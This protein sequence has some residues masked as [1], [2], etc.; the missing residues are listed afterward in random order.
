MT[1][2]K[3]ISICVPVYNE[4]DNVRPLH[5]R[6]RTVM[7]ELEQRY[8][9]EILFTDN[10]SEDR[11]FERLA[12]LALEDK[13]VRVI[14]FSRN[15]GF[16][17]SILANYVH[18]RGVAAIQLDC[19]LQDPPELITEFLR[20][21][22]EGYSVVYGVRGN[23]PRESRFLYGLR[24]IFYRLID[25]LSEDTLP[26]DAGDFRLIDRRVIEELR[27]VRDQQPYLRGLIAA[28]GFRQIGIPYNRAPR[29]RGRSK[30][31]FLRLLGLALDGILHHST[32]P[33]RLA[34]AVGFVM[35]GIAFFGALY[36][37]VAR[38]FGADWPEGWAS[39][40]VLV[41]F[42]IG[43]NAL[44]LGIIGEYIGRIFKNVKPM[45]LVIIDDVIDHGQDR[46]AMNPDPTSPTAE[47][48][49]KVM[50]LDSQQKASGG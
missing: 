43:L 24:R 30:F 12:A 33:L 50:R 48:D 9:Y 40:S 14:R 29:A 42:S 4:E 26:H 36:F 19:D 2:R 25:A 31:S 7:S 44:L 21:W 13:R 23:R 41:L 3:L 46:G 15:F 39:L 1:P 20:R 34:T 35:C 5:E 16:Q 32:V 28:M 37:L 18:A 45:P 10:R 6:V 49:A 17:R 47:I 27:H 11:T 38:S 8:D 22:E